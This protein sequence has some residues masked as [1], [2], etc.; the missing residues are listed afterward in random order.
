MFYAQLTSTAIWR[1]LSS[2][3]KVV[4]EP[5]FQGRLLRPGLNSSGVLK[6]L[7]TKIEWLLWEEQAVKDIQDVLIKRRQVLDKN[8]NKNH[9][10]VSTFTSSSGS[11]RHICRNVVVCVLLYLWY[12]LFRWV[13]FFCFVFTALSEGKGAM[14]WANN[15]QRQTG[16]T[17][18]VDVFIQHWP[19]NASDVRIDSKN[20]NDRLALQTPVTYR[21]IKQWLCT[22][23]WQTY[24]ERWTL[25]MPVTN[26]SYE[27]GDYRC[28]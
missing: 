23:Q 17:N 8:I 24:P 6:P 13:L 19:T 12:V 27:D 2:K 26:W 25:Q 15:C 22:C 5:S 4:T 18:T 11:L 3:G 7:W 14:Y 20:V 10:N 16:P 28:P 21:S 1:R 9:Y